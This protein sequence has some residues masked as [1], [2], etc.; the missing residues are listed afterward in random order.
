[1]GNRAAIAA[2]RDR[3][4]FFVSRLIS[5]KIS[6]FVLGLP[7]VFLLQ[8]RRR[9]VIRQLQPAYRCTKPLYLCGKPPPLEGIHPG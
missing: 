1:M 8:L 2:I 6:W 9:Q 5:P 7:P 4:R 3:P